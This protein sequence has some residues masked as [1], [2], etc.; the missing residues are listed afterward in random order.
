MKSL[1]IAVLTVGCSYGDPGWEQIDSSY[2]SSNP[3]APAPP[4]RFA[5]SPDA[6][7]WAVEMTAAGADAWCAA[8][9]GAWCADV[10]VGA[11]ELDGDW[12][13]VV[14]DLDAAGYGQALGWTF[15]DHAL[16]AIDVHAKGC[17]TVMPHELG[18]A[19][20]IGHLDE[21]LMRETTRCQGSVDTEAVEAFCAAWA[22]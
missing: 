14:A 19:A 1:L 2:E 12:A 7:G 6:P 16:I 9:G 17:A 18:H 10:Y 11:P 4:Q 13:V 20:G 15:N 21:G 22:C 5:V 3:T 8:T